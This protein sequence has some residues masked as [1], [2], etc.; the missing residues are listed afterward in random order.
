MPEHVSVSIVT[1]NHAH[2]IEECLQSL[3]EQTHAPSEILVTDNG[4]TDHTVRVL[5]RYAD[6]LTIRRNACNVGFCA[7]HNEH[8]RACQSPYI[9]VAN[10]DVLFEPT[11]I[12]WALRAFP[13]DP[14]IGTVCGVLYREKGILDSAGL[15]IG[16]NRRFSL[17]GHGRPDDVLPKHDF[18]VFG[19]DGAAPMYRKTMVEDLT[20]DRQFFDEMFFAHKED[21]D[22]SWRARLRGWRT[23]CVREC[24][25]MHPRNFRPGDLARRREMHPRTQYH[26]VKNS[27]LLLIKNDDVVSL[28]RDLLWW[29]PRQLAI[30]GYLV[31]FERESLAAYRFLWQHWQALLSA[32]R[33]I[34]SLRSIGRHELRVWYG[35][36]F[37]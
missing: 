35:Q 14:R 18:E 20:I 7:A 27:L 8:L 25:A 26:A 12:A 30:L 2:C 28:L 10:P 13:G 24:R 11:Y 17:V 3:L 22:V 16:R 15:S 34:K 1:W 5:E 32:R 6:R 36:P 33:R 21:H 4:S 37:R 29:L 9:L 23:I 31:L 19:A